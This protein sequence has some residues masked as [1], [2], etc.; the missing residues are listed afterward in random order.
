MFHNLD[1]LTP[2]T[3]GPSVSIWPAKG[4]PFLHI[5]CDCI[6]N[7]ADSRVIRYVGGGSEKVDIPDGVEIL[8]ARSFRY[9][10]QLCEVRF[11]PLSRL[12]S[13][14]RDAF[15]NSTIRSICIPAPVT[16]L[17]RGALRCV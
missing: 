15:A 5:E 3:R 2:A 10:D 4:Y 7:S 6:I 16:V 1:T 11:G 14:E 17:G 8:G 9:C 13:I 12:S